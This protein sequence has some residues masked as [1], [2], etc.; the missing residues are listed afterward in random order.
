MARDKVE[1]MDYAAMMRRLLRAWGQRVVDAD[2]ED[3][4][5]LLT[6]RQQLDQE[7]GTAIARARAERGLS[8]ADVARA[9]GTSRQNAQQRWGH[10][11]QDR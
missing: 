4:A 5:E 10:Y 1:T 2:P 3:L 8:W 6:F 7:I 9:A 11:G